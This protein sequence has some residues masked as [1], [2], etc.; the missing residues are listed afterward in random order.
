MKP[1]IFN[2]NFVGVHARNNNTGKVDTGAIAFQ[3]LG[4]LCGGGSEDQI[5]YQAGPGIPYRANS[6]SSQKRNHS[7]NKLHLRVCE[8]R[9]ESR[10]ISVT[11][12]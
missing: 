11:L 5:G 3:R 10:R 1:S 12:V 7:L 8:Q 9:I 2:E 6:P 4:V